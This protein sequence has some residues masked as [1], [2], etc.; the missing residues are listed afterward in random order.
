MEMRDV[1]HL[2]KRW[3]IEHDRKRS[4]ASDRGDQ[5]LTESQRSNGVSQN[6]G[7][8]AA[9]QLLVISDPTGLIAGLLL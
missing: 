5:P 7:R 3:F 8:S 2:T 4:Q 6:G 1:G 9:Q